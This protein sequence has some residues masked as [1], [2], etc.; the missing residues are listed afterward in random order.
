MKL[1]KWIILNELSVKSFAKLLNFD[2][3]YI[4]MWLSR[5]KL[6]SQKTLEKIGVLTHGQVC[7]MEDLV[8]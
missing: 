7:R 3:S 4:H 6:P 2:R 8:D 1:R 5:K